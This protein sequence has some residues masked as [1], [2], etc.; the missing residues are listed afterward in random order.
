MRKTN[1]E[2]HRYWTGEMKL[3]IQFYLCLHNFPELLDVILGISL[4]LWL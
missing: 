3:T 2:I 1:L 4:Y